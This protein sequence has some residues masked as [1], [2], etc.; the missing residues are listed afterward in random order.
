MRKLRVRFLEIFRP[1][2]FSSFV[3][4]RRPRLRLR[5]LSLRLALGLVAIT[6]VGMGWLVHR[7]RLQQE[8]IELIRRHGGMYYYDFE[9]EGAAFP[10]SHAPGLRVGWSTIWAS[11]TFIT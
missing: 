11:T 3:T 1:T 10:R 5:R 8:G 2:T 9:N 7:V 4:M 6:A